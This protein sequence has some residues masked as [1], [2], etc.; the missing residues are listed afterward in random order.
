MQRIAKAQAEA[1]YYDE[2]TKTALSIPKDK[3]EAMQAIADVAKARAKNGDISG[4]VAAALSLEQDSWG[5]TDA[6][7]GIVAIQLQRHDLRD[8]GLT[9]EKIHNRV[10]RTI[11]S[12]EIASAFAASRRSQV[13]RNR[14][15]FGFD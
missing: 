14:Q 15:P 3:S 13:R 12:L 7:V 1:G 5:R 11:A 4:A 2:A 6:I 9:S 10:E 8:A